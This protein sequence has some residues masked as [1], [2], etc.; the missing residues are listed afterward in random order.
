MNLNPL[1]TNKILLDVIKE[2]LHSQIDD[3]LYSV[4]PNDKKALFALSKVIKYKGEKTFMKPEE[5][6][7]PGY[8]TGLTYFVN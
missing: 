4:K 6:S 8:L 2:N 3:W 1:Q 5:N 7:R